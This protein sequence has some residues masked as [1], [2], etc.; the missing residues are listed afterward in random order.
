MNYDVYRFGATQKEVAMQEREI[1]IKT[2]EKCHEENRLSMEILDL[3]AQALKAHREWESK[4]AIAQM[5]T[6]LYGYKERL[7]I[8]GKESTTSVADEAIE[9]INVQRDRQRSR[10]RYDD[11]IG[12]LGELSMLALNPADVVLTPLHSNTHPASEYDQTIE[13]HIYQEKLSQKDEAISRHLRQQLPS[14]SAYGNYYLYGS[15]DNEWNKAFESIQPN[16]WNVGLS[17][18]WELFGGFKSTH[19][20]Q[21]LMLEKER[22]QHEYE[23]KKNEYESTVQSSIL[24]QT[25]L[26]QMV[27]QE[28]QLV[29]KT[30]EKIGRSKRLILAGEADAL[31]LLSQKIESAERELTLSIEE[32]QNTYESMMLAFQRT[33]IQECQNRHY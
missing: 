26:T 12:K 28:S 29:S 31:T 22:L 30:D 14:V 16:S 6:Q 19:E 23:L 4:D 25:H 13:A 24:R 15:D 32:I 10:L 8:A 21:T 5:R 1:R 17:V 18:R 7:V 9:I 27:A 11:A 2:I 20:A 3:Y 33:T